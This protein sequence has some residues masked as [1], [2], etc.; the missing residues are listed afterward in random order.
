[1][2]KAKEEQRSVIVFGSFVT[3]SNYLAF[4]QLK[5]DL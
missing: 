5:S 3:V 1:L 2:T 4:S